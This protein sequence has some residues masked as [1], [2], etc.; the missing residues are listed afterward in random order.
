MV[1]EFVPGE[2]TES[3]IV[4]VVEEE[5]NMEQ[6]LNICDGS[7]KDAQ[8]GSIESEQKYVSP[9][10]E[11]SESLENSNEECT[12]WL[13]K[14]LQLPTC[15]VVI[16][17][18]SCRALLDSGSNV[19]FISEDYCTKEGLVIKPSNHVIQGLGGQGVSALGVVQ[20]AIQLG[21]IVLD[22]E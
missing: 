9:E 20:V 4:N 22:F 6:D 1:P 7:I 12:V 16:G 15:P 10:E 18:S 8:V 19:S 13:S 21:A 3:I 14:G 17:S 2:D 5:Q 11:Q